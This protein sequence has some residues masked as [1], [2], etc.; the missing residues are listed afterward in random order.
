MVPIIVQTM[1]KSLIQRWSDPQFVAEVG[2]LI[3][4]FSLG[5]QLPENAD[6]RGIVVGLDGAWP[7]LLHGDFIGVNLVQIDASY[8]R[9]SCSFADAKASKCMFEETIFDTCLFQKAELT[10]CNF[11]RAKLDSP[12]FNDAIFRKCEF[13]D[14]RITGRR[15]R[16]YGGRRISFTNCA[17]KNTLFQNLQFRAT[18]FQNCTFEGAQFRKC[19]LA[20]VKF[21]GGVP[22]KEAFQNCEVQS[23]TVD[24]NPM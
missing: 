13:E 19:L 22:A 10:Q 18:T 8:G 11:S 17:F 20:G 5:R 15:I 7:E 2:P 6:L 16:E 9:F 14:A 12:D 21:Q 4:P 24:G 3:R 23:V 1:K